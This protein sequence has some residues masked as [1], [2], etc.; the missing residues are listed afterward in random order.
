MSSAEIHKAAWL[1]DQ[2]AQD[3][4]LLDHEFAS[5]SLD[6]LPGL[7]L[8]ANIL[9]VYEQ[10]TP[11]TRPNE[12]RP[13]SRKWLRPGGRAAVVTT[14]GSQC[15]C[16][17]ERIGVAT[18]LDDDSVLSPDIDP[19]ERAADPSR[20]GDAVGLAEHDRS[21][22]RH[23][24]GGG[25][26]LTVNGA[27]GACAAVNWG[28]CVRQHFGHGLARGGQKFAKDGLGLLQTDSDEEKASV[29]AWLQ[30]GDHGGQHG[31]DLHPQ[32]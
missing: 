25:F 11:E 15:T 26:A 28:S 3:F 21:R 1:F 32:C 22:S 8:S 14:R 10:V 12:P 9:P 17:A 31:D 30:Y 29:I 5:L 16:L 27:V 18:P 13:M 20:R 2:H 24:G 19:G 23:T 4:E 6:E 7:D